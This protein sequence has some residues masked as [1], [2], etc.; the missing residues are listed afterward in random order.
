MKDSFD[1]DLEVEKNEVEPAGWTIKTLGKVC[2]ITLVAC[3]PTMPLVCGGD[4][5]TARAC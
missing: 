1:L 4:Y 3:L 2:T 5:S